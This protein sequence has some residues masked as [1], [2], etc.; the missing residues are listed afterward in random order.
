MT[1]EEKAKA[2]DKAIERVRELLSCCMDDRERRTKVYR[3]EDIESIFPEL[4][5][6]EDERIRNYLI[7]FVEVNSG[8]NLPPEDAEQM[9]AWLEKQGKI[10]DYYEDRLDECACKYFNKGYKH[11]LEKQG[12][13]TSLQTNE[14]L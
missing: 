8:F 10:V 11:A 6:S 14:R 12:E 13:Q 9:L 1:T 2:Y 5:E 3:V 7:S 4:V